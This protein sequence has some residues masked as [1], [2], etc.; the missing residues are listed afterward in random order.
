MSRLS[1]IDALKDNCI[2]NGKLITGYADEDGITVTDNDAVMTTT[3][4]VKGE[5]YRSAHAAVTSKITLRLNPNSESAAYLMSLHNG[6]VTGFPIVVTSA[7]DLAVTKVSA[8]DCAIVKAPDINFASKSYKPL[9]FE[10]EAIG[11]KRY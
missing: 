1:T 7:N 9:T 10:I 5:G 4:G 8:P 2:V 11:L 3:I 6:R